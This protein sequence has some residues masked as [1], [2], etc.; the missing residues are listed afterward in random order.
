M[1]V[2]IKD[3]ARGRAGKVEIKNAWRSHRR[4]NDGPHI[5]EIV[6]AGAGCPERNRTAVDLGRLILVN[7]HTVVANGVGY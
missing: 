4:R 2:D 7:R 6:A 5:F 3:R 1:T